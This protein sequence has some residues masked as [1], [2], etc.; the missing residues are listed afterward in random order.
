MLL[1]CR[2]ILFL[3]IGLTTEA[4]CEIPTYTVEQG[5]AL[6]IE[7]NPDIII[8]RKK[9]E[10]ARGG[11]IEARSGYLPSLLSTGFADKRET[12]TPNT[13][14]QQDYSAIV[15]AQE[16]VYTGG[17][18]SSRVAIAKLNIEKQNYEL[19]EITNGVVRDV[20]IAFYDL[21]LNRAKVRVHEDSVRALEEELKTQQ[22]RLRAGMVGT[23]NVHRAEVALANERPDLINANTQLQDSYLQLC[24][25]LGM[26]ARSETDRSFE[27]A[28]QL[29]YENQ[30]PDLSEC[31]ARADA[32][33]PEIKERQKDIEIEERQYVLDRSDLLPQVQVFSGYEVYSENDPAAGPEFNNGYV[34]G[35]TGSWHIF[36][37]FAAK[38]KMKATRAEREA[39]VQAL[40]A[41]RR[42][43]ASEVRRAFLD[44]E[45]ADKVLQSET[46]NVQTADESLE[47]A[48]TNLA[49]GLGTQLDVL[50]A[51]A[52]VTR[53]RTTRLSAIYM[54][55]AALAQLARACGSRPG[56]LNFGSN[57]Q[58]EHHEKQA[59][60]LAHPPPKLSGR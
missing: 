51:T 22:E 25:L 14:R 53:T 40:E 17:A 9:L 57:T 27:V 38:G 54:H 34:V 48:K 20:R 42:T 32:D 55:D 10:A 41:E 12:Q 59:L 5:V 7:H 44:L 29:Q 13:L 37:G 36:D 23:L 1:G 33:R 19:E 46:K 43:V 49:A 6:A 45:Q 28:G 18:V 15:R 26:D 47:I 56:T 52:D 3:V 24:E 21:L 35:V 31:L 4:K 50:Q 16:N 30:H 11:L 2:L 39:D 8:A 58:K 60:D